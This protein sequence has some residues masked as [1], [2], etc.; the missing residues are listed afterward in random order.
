MTAQLGGGGMEGMNSLVEPMF[1]YFTQ[2][3]HWMKLNE[4]YLSE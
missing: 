2:P 1:K 3:E 4:R